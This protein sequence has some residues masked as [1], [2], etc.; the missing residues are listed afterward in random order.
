MTLK[1]LLR[2]IKPP[3]KKKT[4]LTNYLNALHSVTRMIRNV[5]RSVLKNIR[6]VK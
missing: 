6:N 1:M 5:R 3:K 4:V 2:E